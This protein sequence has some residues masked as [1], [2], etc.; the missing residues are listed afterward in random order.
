MDR[1]LFT[2]QID[3]PDAFGLQN[4]EQIVTLQLRAYCIVSHCRHWHRFHAHVDKKPICL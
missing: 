2:L 1:V 4:V 3:D